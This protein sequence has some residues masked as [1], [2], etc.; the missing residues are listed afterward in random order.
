M[1]SVM[2][3]YLARREE[4]AVFPRGVWGAERRSAGSARATIEGA[5]FDQHSQLAKR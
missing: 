2:T 3:P 1:S 4:L 5:K